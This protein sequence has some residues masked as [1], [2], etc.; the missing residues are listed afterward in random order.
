MRDCRYFAG[1]DGDR[2]RLAGGDIWRVVERAGKVQS[3]AEVSDKFEGERRFRVFFCAIAGR[4][5]DACGD[6]RGE[7]ACN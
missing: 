3:V 2:R 6:R 7:I 4:Q 1:G 5:G